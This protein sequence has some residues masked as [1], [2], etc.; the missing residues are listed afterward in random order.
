MVADVVLG[1]YPQ[2][3][4]TMVRR[5]CQRES[6]TRQE[7]I[8]LIAPLLRRST[9][10]AV[11]FPGNV[12]DGEAHPVVHAITRR[13]RLG[14]H[15]RLP[16]RAE[17]LNDNAVW[18]R[19]LAAGHL[20]IRRLYRQAYDAGVADLYD[21]VRW[22]VE[23]AVLTRDCVLLSKL[24]S[25][26]VQLDLHHVLMGPRGS[27]AYVRIVRTLLHHRLSLLPHHTKEAHDRAADMANDTFASSIAHVMLAHAVATADSSLC[28]DTLSLVDAAFGRNAARYTA[29]HLFCGGGQNAVVPTI[30]TKE[31]ASFAAV[32]FPSPCDGIDTARDRLLLFRMVRHVQAYY[33][34]GE[35][36]VL[37]V[38]LAHLRRHVDSHSL[39]TVLAAFPLCTAVGQLPLPLVLRLPDEGDDDQ[40]RRAVATTTTT[41]TTTNDD[42]DEAR[43]DAICAQSRALVVFR[44]EHRRHVQLHDAI[45]EYTFKFY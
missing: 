27:P 13:W 41:S 11:A 25:A 44:K 35:S 16:E 45:E 28:C 29:C 40:P 12:V 2:Y 21:R 26:W 23:C 30:P 36:P 5:I 1:A 32:I 6:T 22:I 39:C 24:N 3:F 8:T 15:P 17:C 18:C 14:F 43:L 20:R 4:E 37:S 34:T 7:A 42:T 19:F 31:V 9:L 10:V 38:I 33:A